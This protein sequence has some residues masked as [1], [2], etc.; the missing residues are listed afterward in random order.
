MLY[1]DDTPTIEN[2]ITRRLDKESGVTVVNPILT[3]TYVKGEWY[4]DIETGLERKAGEPFIRV[5]VQVILGPAELGTA[6]SWFDLPIPFEH[7]HLLNE[8]D[9]IA[10][11]CKLALKDIRMA[12]WDRSARLAKGTG[13]R[14]NWG[15]YGVLMAKRG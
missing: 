5:G 12:P 14:G 11:Q 7:G 9:Q 4:K 2:A 1:A 15:R 10:E 6:R 3:K 13:L 8:I